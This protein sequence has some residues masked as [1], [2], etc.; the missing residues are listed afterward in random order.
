MELLVEE[1]ALALGAHVISV[2][3]CNLHNFQGDMGMTLRL[4]DMVK[5]QEVILCALS[6]ITGGEDVRQYVEQSVGAILVGEALMH[7]KDTCIF[8]AELLDWADTKEPKVLWPLVVKICGIRTAEE[9]LFS[10]SVGAA[11]LSMVFVPASKW[12]VT[13]E[14][15]LFSSLSCIFL[16]LV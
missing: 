7:A 13:L 11:M 14:Q 5:G 6:G 16:F 4:A 15:V 1:E 10:A 12:C 2:N 3:N 9:A 8:I